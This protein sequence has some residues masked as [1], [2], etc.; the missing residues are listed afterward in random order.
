MRRWQSTMMNKRRSLRGDT[1]K[2]DTKQ[3]NTDDEERAVSLS[4]IVERAKTALNGAK[5]TASVKAKKLSEPIL[6]RLLKILYKKGETPVSI[7]AKLMG[8][9]SDDN[10]FA[11]MYKTWS[12]NVRAKTNA[13]Q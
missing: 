5:A 13:P 9:G 3:A 1:T 6:E 8:G 7:R 11:R 10:R 2:I 4:N 12:E